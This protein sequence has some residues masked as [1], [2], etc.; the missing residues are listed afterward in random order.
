MHIIIGAI[1]AI[2]GLIWALHSLQNS[3]V[4]LNSF[5]PLT[6]ARRRQWEKTYGMKPLFN[7]K[8]PMDSAAALIVGLLKQEG[9]ISK[10]QKAAVIKLFQNEFQLDESKATELFVSSAYLSKDEMDFAGC[11]PKVLELSKKDFTEE[12]KGLLLQMLK[13]VSELENNPNDN[14]QAII[15]TVAKE[16]KVN[17]NNNNG[18]S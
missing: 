1:T 6:W 7:L 9:E 17:R 11:V 16:L 10:E 4:D 3:G 8:S 15:K 12:Q 13:T 5:N 18:W 14:Q 2:A